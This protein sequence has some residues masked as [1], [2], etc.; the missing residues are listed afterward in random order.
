M[1]QNIIYTS[2]KYVL[3]DLVGDILYF[4]LWWYTVGVKKMV[5]KSWNLIKD[6]QEFLG[7]RVW[8]INIFQ[9]MFGQYDLVG[10]LISFVMRLIQIIFRGIFLIIW[11]M[12]VIGLFLLWLVGPLIIFYQIGYQLS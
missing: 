10:R 4:P 1:T 8:V 11:I 6:G 7:L 5:L 3:R 2:V 9:P 12:V